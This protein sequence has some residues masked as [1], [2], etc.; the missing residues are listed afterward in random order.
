MKHP[1]TKKTGPRRR[2]QEAKTL[3][4]LRSGSGGARD[5]FCG[6]FSSLSPPVVLVYEMKSPTGRIAPISLVV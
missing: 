4:S 1:E 2:G 3:A 5:A 6:W